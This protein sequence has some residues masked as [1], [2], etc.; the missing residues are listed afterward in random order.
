MAPELVR[1]Q[2]YCPQKVDDWSLGV[3][4]FAM[5]AGEFPFRGIN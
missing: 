5:L 2:E 4:I 1:H 3:T